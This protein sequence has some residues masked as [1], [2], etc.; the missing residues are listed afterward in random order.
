M[1]RL[2][3]ARRALAL[4][5]ALASRAWIIPVYHNIDSPGA[6]GFYEWED[7]QSDLRAI[8]ARDFRVAPMNDV[9]LYLREREHAEVTMQVSE[10]DGVTSR[11]ALVLADGLDNDRYDQPLTVLFTPPAD[12][13][14][15]AVEVTRNGRFVARIPAF[16]EEAAIALLPHEEPY[17]LQP[18]HA[19]S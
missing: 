3:R 9:V 1:R 19:Q 11:I 2:V 16:T 13:F 7:F 4:R 17:F 10:R 6:W 12:W 8:A 18:V 14:G 5:R 15:A